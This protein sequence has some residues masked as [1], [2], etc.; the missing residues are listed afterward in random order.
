MN[1]FEK[2]KRDLEKALKEKDVGR[3]S[4]LRFLIAQIQNRE[5]ELNK[6]GQLSDEEVVEVIRK[7]AKKHQESIEAYQ[8]GRR[9]DLVKKE[10]GELK[11]LNTYL[12][13]KLSSQNLEKIISQTIEEVGAKGPEDFGKGM[14]AVMGKVKGRAD[15]QE[16]AKL[17][18][19]KLETGN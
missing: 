11:I 18:K 13:Q 16:V 7:Q 19:E 10:K 6:R 12:P 1:L 5:I 4:T 9:N 14:G 15:G 17:V 2:I 8:K 3:V